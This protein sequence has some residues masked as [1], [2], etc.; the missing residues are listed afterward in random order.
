MKI[1]LERVVMLVLLLLMILSGGSCIF[2]GCK[3][4]RIRKHCLVKCL[5]SAQSAK[6]MLPFLW[7]LLFFLFFSFI[8][9]NQWGKNTAGK[10]FLSQNKAPTE[11]LQTA[12]F[13]A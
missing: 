8:S 5:S 13:C 6:G 1:I 3:V 10:E 7:I 12:S 4:F 11:R 9:S 2:T